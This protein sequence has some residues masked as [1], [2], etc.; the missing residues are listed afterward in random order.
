MLW[1]KSHSKEVPGIRSACVGPTPAL[2]AQ[3][4]GM[5]DQYLRWPVATPPGLAGMVE[6]AGPPSWLG[7]RSRAQRRMVA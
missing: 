2:C 4:A 5:C 3:A 1:P 6:E 7:S